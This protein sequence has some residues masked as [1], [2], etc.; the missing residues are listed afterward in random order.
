MVKHRY[1]MQLLKDMQQFWSF[2]WKGGAYVDELDGH[3]HSFVESWTALH[4]A[5]YHGH[6][7]AVEM[8]YGRTNIN[9]RH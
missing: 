8:L 7:D 4:L 1:I 6:V 2:C 5:A 9:P 3:V